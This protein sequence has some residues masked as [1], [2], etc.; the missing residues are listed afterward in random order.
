MVDKKKFLRKPLKEDE[1]IV[2][3]MTA[4]Q[5][6]E[7]QPATTTTAPEQAAA[8]AASTA[9]D[10]TVATP[11]KS[12][13]LTPPAPGMVPTGWA[14]PEQLSKA[15]AMKTGD[16]DV[17]QDAPDVGK[18]QVAAPENKENGEDEGGGEIE[19]ESLSS[20]KKFTSILKKMIEEEERENPEKDE[21]YATEDPAEPA[22]EAEEGD[23][24]AEETPTDETE[25]TADEA[26]EGKED[27]EPADEAEEVVSQEEMPDA[28]RQ[29]ADYLDK[30]FA[31]E[32]ENDELEDEDNDESDDEKD[33]SE[34]EPE[35]ESDSD[36]DD[37]ELDESDCD[38]D[39]ELEDLDLEE[40]HNCT[41]RLPKGMKEDIV[42]PAGSSVKLGADGKSV[43]VKP[44]EKADEDDEDLIHR[45]ESRARARREAIRKARAARKALSL[46]EEGYASPE[47]V[48]QSI[49]WEDVQDIID[50]TPSEKFGEAIRG[51]QVR[52]MNSRGEDR[53]W[54]NQNFEE[55]YRESARLN[56]K[57]LL[58]E[59]LLG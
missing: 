34:D 30:L 8:P 24:A 55:K 23:A 3:P 41:W 27:E 11:D 33:E 2:E 44:I 7:P 12:D 51:H 26:G 49:D 58:S 43:A 54:K 18:S 29:A 21:P 15:I 28:L 31:D 39:D 6:P 19:L 32:D 1:Q 53:S 14:Y 45:Y 13:P 48:D 50:D 38:E 59:G 35:D 17:A 42:Y 22:D 40:G 52:R 9:V 57:E 56:F 4:Q 10:Q 16:V 36:E 37:G 46:K 25:E 20:K 5:A 47:D